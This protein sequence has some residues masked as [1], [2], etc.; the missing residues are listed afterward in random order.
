MSSLAYRLAA[1]I[2][3]DLGIR[4]LPDTFRR[5]YAGYWM[6]TQGAFAWEMDCVGGGTV[7]SMW[8]ASVLLKAGKPLTFDPREG[9]IFPDD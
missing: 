5:T 4:C 8:P 9:E 1:K 2:E 7:G 3:R 6:K